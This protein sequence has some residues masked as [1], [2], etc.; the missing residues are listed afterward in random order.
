VRLVLVSAITTAVA[1][2]VGFRFTQGPLAVL[3]FFAVVVL[4]AWIFLWLAVVLA[5]SASSE[6][7]VS[8]ALS[9]PVTL[10]LFL[11]S[12]FVPVEQFPEWLRPVVRANPMSVAGDAMIGLSSGGRILLPVLFTALWAVAATAIL[13]PLAVRLYK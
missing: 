1:Y 5:M 10:L 8:G 11:S 9:S 12:G 13:V 3:G 6:Q 2:A 4:F 7:A